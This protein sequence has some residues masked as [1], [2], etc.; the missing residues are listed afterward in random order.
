MRLKEDHHVADRALLLPRGDERVGARPS[1]AAHLAQP[2]RLVVEDLER[3]EPELLDDP[4][5]GD[6]A[7]ALDEPGAEVLLDPDSVVGASSVTL[8]ARSCSPWF[9]ST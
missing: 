9:L 2:M 8:V 6:L 7:D 1:E 4:L 5:R 3:L